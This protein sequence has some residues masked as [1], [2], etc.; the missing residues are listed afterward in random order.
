MSPQ[1]TAT[2]AGPPKSN[3][4]TLYILSVLIYL[5]HYFL[6]YWCM[7]DRCDDNWFKFFRYEHI[8]DGEPLDKLPM[9]PM[10]SL[11][12]S[13]VCQTALAHYLVHLVAQ[14][15]QTAY[16]AS[17]EK[18]RGDVGILVESAK[19]AHAMVDDRLGAR[20]KDCLHSCSTYS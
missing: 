20:C 6:L 9:S 7:K 3:V 15:A 14:N 18:I 11:E 1:A 19:D 5:F 10:F 8:K 12:I 17:L 16:H 2:P 4:G 13:L